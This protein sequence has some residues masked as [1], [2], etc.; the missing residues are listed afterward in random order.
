VK[1]IRVSGCPP[2]AAYRATT[3]SLCDGCAVGCVRRICRLA[4]A[5]TVCALLLTASCGQSENPNPPTEAATAVDLSAVYGSANPNNGPAFLLQMGYPVC[6]EMQKGWA[7]DF[8]L[9]SV[10][11]AGPLRNWFATTAS[12]AVH[13]VSANAQRPSH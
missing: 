8:I 13:R 9:R 11:E 10:A 7:R 12:A 5:A 2:V 4:I 6:D 1:A 3:N